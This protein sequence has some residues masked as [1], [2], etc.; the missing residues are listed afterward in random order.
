[1]RLVAIYLAVVSG[2]AVT[3]TATGL[4]RGR[5][6]A[7]AL[8]AA[9]VGAVLFSLAAGRGT[10]RPAAPA[11]TDTARPRWP[12]WIVLALGALFVARTTFWLAWYR[13]GRLVVGSPNNLGDFALHLTH[14]QHLARGA[15]FWPANPIAGADQLAYPLG[16]TLWQRLLL[17]LGLPTLGVFALATLLGL[18]A[19]VIA[20]WRWGGA[21]GLAALL[22]NGGLAGWAVLG[23]TVAD[24]QADLAWK[25]IP[26]ALLVTQRGLLYAVPAGLWLMHRWQR[27]LLA[28]EA[29]PGWLEVWVYATLPLFHL[30]TFLALSFV[31]A[32]WFLVLPQ[33][34]RVLGYGLKSVP[35]AA[36]LA[37][38]CT[39]GA[40]QTGAAGFAWGWFERDGQGAI[41][42]LA[43]NFGA[44]LLLI[45]GLAVWLAARLIRRRADAAE[46]IAACWFGPGLLLLAGCLVGKLQPWAWDN[47]KLM[48]WGWLMTAPFA[49]TLWLRHWRR[50]IAWPAVALLFGGGIATL[51]GGLAAGMRGGFTVVKRFDVDAATI[52]V[53][54]LS[55]DEI[56]AAAPDYNQ[57]LLLAGQCTVLGYEGHLWSHGIDFHRRLE[58]LD[59]LMNGAPGWR[60][61]ARALGVRYLYWGRLEIRTYPRSTQAWFTG[62]TAVASSPAGTLYR[63]AD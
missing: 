52:A 18:S 62:A 29:R 20:A 38:W 16:V 50:A 7:L 43:E 22:A 36:V 45:P 47:T 56:V 21:F 44:W 35:L 49:W 30:H 25:S 2:A 31:L 61:A 57:P 33:R 13:D 12:D 58:Q 26:L 60:E 51:G 4:L 34:R 19:T 54:G 37:W 27:T 32:C 39:G 42:A 1:M 15:G 24:F 28:E 10:R 23:G 9:G 11:A 6:D 3:M 17:G 40:H 53:R 8:G 55:P 41:A 48:L 63:L 14:L 5:I 59:T 46:R